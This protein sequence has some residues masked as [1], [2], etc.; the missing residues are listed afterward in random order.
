M[1][2]IWYFWLDHIVH[3]K[4]FIHHNHLPWIILWLKFSYM[5]YLVYQIILRSYHIWNVLYKEL[6]QY[7]FKFILV[8][9][10]YCIWYFWFYHVVHMKIFIHQNYLVTLNYFVTYLYEISCISNN[11]LLYLIW[12]SL[13]II[14]IYHELFCDLNLLIWNILY[15]K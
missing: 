11:L 1:S 3:M 12:K 4:M 13:S 5:K 8:I 2:C 9:L 7:N 14:I 15:I 6:F 10:I